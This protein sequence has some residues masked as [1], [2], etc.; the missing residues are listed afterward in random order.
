MLPR[1]SGKPMCGQ[2]LSSAI[3]SSLSDTTRTGPLGVLTTLQRL[4]RNSPSVQTRMKLAPALSMGRSVRRSPLHC[5]LVATPSTGARTALAAGRLYHRRETPLPAL[6]RVQGTR[7]VKG[8]RHGGARKWPL[9]R[10]ALP[11]PRNP[12]PINHLAAL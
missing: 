12:L 6:S 7:S 4:A 3:T 11:P 5:K 8:I 1:C 9:L 10:E 2:R